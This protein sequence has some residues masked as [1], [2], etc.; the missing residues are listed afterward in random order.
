MCLRQHLTFIYD[1]EMISQCY[2]SCRVD[3][4]MIIWIDF[5]MIIWIVLSQA[6]LEQRC[7]CCESL[8]VLQHRSYVKQLC[9]T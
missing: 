9:E 6:V 5:I 3:F 1:V 4:I 2:A 8:A 7:R